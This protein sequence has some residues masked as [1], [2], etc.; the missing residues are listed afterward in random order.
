MKKET[1]NSGQK[2]ILKA[3]VAY[4]IIWNSQ[5]IWEYL[6]GIFD[7]I[8][9][10]MLLITIVILVIVGIYQLFKFFTEKP[11]INFR[12]LN[13]GL[14]MLI[15]VLSYFKPLGLIDFEK[16]EGENIVYAM[17]EGVA[18]CT[19]SIRLKSGNKFK[20]TSICFGK[21]HYWGKYEI[22]NDTIKFHYNRT[23]E[24]NKEDD[25]AILQL[26]DDTTSQRL[27]LIHYHSTGLRKEGIPMIIRELKIDK[28][29]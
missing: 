9:I 15:S 1:L 16:Y 2:K 3:I 17:Y 4:V 18:N 20:K 22:V 27:G 24:E 11:T 12:L 25:Y 14:I 8:I 21:D 7:M 5:Y 29:R 28:L 19:T 10:I 6:P 26:E 23:S 13:I